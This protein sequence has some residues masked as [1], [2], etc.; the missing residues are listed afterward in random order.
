[1]TQL[2]SRDSC[3]SCAP[4]LDGL[5]RAE[6]A[7]SQHVHTHGERPGGPFDAGQKT[8]QHALATCGKGPFCSVRD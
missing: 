4:C 6:A 1:M 3:A 5:P 2:D 7:C 8:V